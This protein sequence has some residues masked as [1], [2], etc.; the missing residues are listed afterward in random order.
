VSDTLIAQEPKITVELKEGAISLSL[1]EK[2]FICK[3]A[4]PKLIAWLK[5]YAAKKPLPPFP[6]PPPKASPFFSRVLSAMQ[7]IPFGET[8]SYKKLAKAAKN[9]GAF[10]AVG[11]ACRTNPYPLLIPCHRVLKS[12]GTLGGFAFGLK[13]KERLLKFEGAL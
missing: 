10:R 2:G 4:H 7:K 3:T 9:P 12:D 8:F 11:S 5:A 1:N 6:L 13:M